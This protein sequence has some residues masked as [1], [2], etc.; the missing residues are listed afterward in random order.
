MEDTIFNYFLSII[1]LLWSIFDY[2]NALYYI[3]STRSSAAKNNA[4]YYNKINGPPIT[5]NLFGSQYE[6]L[7]RH[8]VMYTDYVKLYYGL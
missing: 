4:L 5:H 1:L 2:R 8:L 6:I 3:I 7:C